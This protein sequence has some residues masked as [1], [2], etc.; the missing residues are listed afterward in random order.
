MTNLILVILKKKK[1]VNQI[2]EL[3]IDQYRIWL[4]IHNQ[5]HVILIFRIRSLYDP[6]SYIMFLFFTS[7]KSIF[8]GS[9]NFIVRKWRRIVFANMNL[10]SILRT[11]IIRDVELTKEIFKCIV[12]EINYLWV[13]FRRDRV[14]SRVFWLVCCLVPWRRAPTFRL[15]ELFLR[16]TVFHGNRNRKY[17]F[18]FSLE[19]VNAL[20]KKGTVWPFVLHEG[21]GT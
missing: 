10:I 7:K 19:S 11:L 9:S 2:E 1:I 20:S 18:S 12:C 8:S 16:N 3:L 17:A 21:L 13:N 5:I 6:G 4:N 15:Q 14:W